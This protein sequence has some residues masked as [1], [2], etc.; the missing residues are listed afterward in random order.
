MR[1]STNLSV[2][3]KF[4]LTFMAILTIS[5]TCM[6]YMLYDQASQSAIAQGKILMMQ[7]VQQ[8]R[9]NMLQKVNMVQ[10]LSQIVAFDPKLQN[11]LNSAFLNDSYQLEEYRDTIAPILDNLKRQNSY[12]HSIRIYMANESIP[13]MYDGFYHISRIETNPRYETFLRDSGQ[14]SLWQ[15]MH[16]EQSLLTVPGVAGDAEVVSFD[17]KIFS[18][19]YTDMVG[20]LEIEIEREEFFD[21]LYHATGS[22]KGEIYVINRTGKVV[23]DNSSGGGI[24]VSALNLPVMLFD[25]SFNEVMDVNGVSSI[26]ISTPLVGPKMRMIGVFPVEPFIAGMEKSQKGIIIVLVVSLL[27]LGIIVYFI[28]SALLGRM[29]VLLSAMKK[30]REGNLNVSVPIQSNDEFGQMALTFNLMTS[31]IHDLVESVYKSR[32][33]EKEAELRA[34]ESQ[35][36]PHFLYNT[37]ATIAWVARKAQVPG[38]VHLSNS[39][40]KFYRLVLNRGKSS[41]SVSDE[42][43]MVRAYAQIQKFRFEELFDIVFDVDEA[44]LSYQMAKNI[45]QPLVENALAHGIEPKRAHGTIIVKA[46]VTG[47]KLVFQIIDDGVGMNQQRIDD[48]LSGNIQR[49]S[50]SGY[51]VKNIIERL[52]GYYGH[53]GGSGVEIW[54]RSGIG[55][56]V[57]VTLPKG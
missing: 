34:L 46:H 12:I 7:N 6:G 27:V 24:D 26:V 40:A 10:N 16:Q 55:T 33:V 47:D 14:T 21:M 22:Y 54:S 43:E 15:E 13:E 35:I 37:L 18:S 49:T 36:N 38:I 32:I 29:K 2:T 57:T 4:V 45:L 20:I 19:S 25:D 50:G 48:V 56:V 44:V 23:F 31:R 30:V 39:L 17:R 42:I 51:A 53:H 11:F 52:T 41:I 28:T 9:N 5:M 8:M 3:S 1:L